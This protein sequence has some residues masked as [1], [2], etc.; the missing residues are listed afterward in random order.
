MKDVVHYISQIEEKCAYIPQRR[1]LS[2][3]FFSLLATRNAT[4]WLFFGTLNLNSCK[5][6][7]D[8]DTAAV[9]A[10]DNLLAHADVELTLRWNLVEATTASVTLHVD[11]AETI[12]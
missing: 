12:A 2:F 5:F 10:H 11:N 9:F 1:S 8:H 6:G 7:V 3:G 4:L